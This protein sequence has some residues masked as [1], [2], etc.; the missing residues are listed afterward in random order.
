MPKRPKPPTSE[1]GTSSAEGGYLGWA[2][3]AGGD[4]LEYVAELQWPSSVNAYRS[5]MNDA[6]VSSLMAGLVLPIRAY[7]WYIEPNGASQSAIDRI[8]T[9]YNLPIGE[10]E[11]DEEFHRRR[12]ARR[13][14]FDKHLED[15]LRALVYG[16]FPF[17][18]VG[19]I[20]SDGQ[21]HLR[22]LG[23]RAP[24]TVSEIHVAEDG[25]LDWIKQNYGIDPPE[26]PINRLVWYVWDREGAN[27]TGR[28][29]LRPVYRNYIVKDR[30]LRVGAINI[31]RAGGIPYVNAPEGASGDQIK[32]L[33]ALA[34]R[35]RVGEAAGAALP[36]G[37]QLK[38]AA[39]A[40]GDGSVAYI[41]QQNE[42][43]ARAFLQMVNMLGQ[44]NSG[45]R[46]LGD[47]FHDIVRIAQYT[48]AKWFCD[49]FNEH[50]I[51]D[52]V[53]WNEGPEE[54]FAPL[55][56][57]EAGLQDPMEG[58]RDKLDDPDGINDVDPET[59]SLMRNGERLKKTDRRP[60]PARSRA[61]KAQRV[62]AV[63]DRGLA[64]QASL[65]PRP[66][67]REP[68]AHEVEAAVDFASMDAT[69]DAA[70]HQ[71]KSEIKLVR[72]FQIDELHDAIVA[73]DGDVAA[74]A[75][76]STSVSATERILAQIRLAASVAADQAVQE[77]RRQGVRIP[78]TD[79]SDIESDLRLR[80][81]AVDALLTEDITQSARREAIRLTGGGLQPSEV[82]DEVSTFLTALSGA[83][84]ADILG[85][86][87]QYSINEGRKL[88]YRTD[89]RAG[90]IYASELLDSSTCSDCVKIDG[91]EYE[92][93]QEAERD[94]PTGGYRNC[95]GRERCRGTL[96]KRYEVSF[97][98][99]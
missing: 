96:I 48:I 57:F 64:S 56:K 92:S 12:G 13:F 31:E 73:A 45:S 90:T 76:I 4:D 5:M 43:M 21:W 41:K 87:T 20:G 78:R 54:E 16:H 15:A 9:D 83:A 98:A 82:A 69:Y 50:V 65:P 14:S 3:W 18:Q 46:G 27:W 28:S 2:S 47:T 52:D 29:M 36:Y 37:A 62:E 80:S 40:G 60:K 51:E 88:V 38:F 32:E 39:A 23:V 55:L 89:G 49:T 94:Y 63:E 34:R 8:S 77:A 11:D 1:L 42:E 86:A 10:K 99:A 72:S 85:G 61:R 70:L 7:R 44:T 79:V 75:R 81:E 93:V 74:L 68:F 17:E 6:Q 35:F 33:D 26:I 97:D 19:E 53:E 24:H 22:K 71:S 59:E 30:V 58:F 95:Q 84:A 67:R 66:L 25:S 91:T